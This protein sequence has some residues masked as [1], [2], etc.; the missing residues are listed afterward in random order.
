MTKPPPMPDFDVP[1]TT[2][3]NG[4][5]TTVWWEWLQRFVRWDEETSGGGGGGTPGAVSSVTGVSPIVATGTALMGNEPAVEPLAAGDVT[6]SIP[7]A[8]GAV[9]GYLTAADW[10]TFFNKAPLNSPAFL[11]NPTAPTPAAGDNDTSIATTAFVANAITTRAPLNSPAF[12]GSPTAPTPPPGD[13]DISIA[14]TDFVV[15]AIAAAGGAGVAISDTPPASPLVGQFWLEA[16]SGTLFVRWQ[17]ANS[18]QWVDVSGSSALENYLPLAGGSMTG[19]LTLHADPD[20]AMKAATKQY[21][22]A[23][24]TAQNTTI[25]AKADTTAVNAGLALKANLTGAV[26]TGDITTYRTGGTTGAI[27]LNSAGSRYLYND[28]T[29]YQLGGAGNIWHSGNLDPGV[30]APYSWVSTYFAQLSGAAFTGAVQVAG[31]LYNAGA[32]TTAAVANAHISNADGNHFYRNN[33]SLQ[34]KTAVE[35][36]APEY[37]D[38]ILALKPIFYRGNEKSADDPTWSWFGFSAENCDEVDFR[39]CS[40]TV[41]EPVKEGE[42]WQDKPLVPEN[43]HTHGILAALVELVQRQE[44]RIQALEAALAV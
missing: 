32:P 10:T 17:D 36:L 16:D 33:S 13:A 30:Y 3:P 5:L 27:F 19:F 44:K 29:N 14:T 24:N 37:G 40:Y 39:F 42:R 18:Q 28:G 26:F 7:A 21:V 11:G 43:I 12:T 34:Y 2:P 41:A 6:V 20:A 38:K 25:A 8:S 4:K 35:P 22:D 9:S 15:S 1:I 23:A 31:G